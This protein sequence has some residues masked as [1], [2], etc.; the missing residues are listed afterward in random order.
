MLALA[1]CSPRHVLAWYSRATR[2]SPR[3]PPPADIVFNS[4]GCYLCDMTDRGPY[5]GPAS[6]GLKA[7]PGVTSWVMP[8]PLPRRAA[9]YFAANLTV[10]AA[11]KSEVVYGLGQGGWTPE[12][13]CPAAGAAGAAIVPLERNG[14]TVKLQQRKFHVSIPFLSSTAGY[15]F[16]FNMPGYGGV[17]IGEHGVGG[18]AWSQEAALYL[19]FW[20]TTL[21][22]DVV[23]PAPGPIYHQYADATGHAPPLREDAMSFWQSRNRYKSNDIALSIADRYQQ[24]KLD[25]GVL[26][27]DYKNQLRD[28]D[29]APN[30]A[31]YPS[32][33]AL[34]SGVRKK[35]NATLMYSFWPEVWA[36]SP[37]YPVLR[38]AGCLINPDLSGLAFDATIPTCRELVWSKM[39]KPRYYDQGVDAF[40][41]DETDGEGTGGGGDGDYGYN[42][43]YG[44]AVAYSNLWVNE[45][46]SMYSDPVA[47]QPGQVAPPLVLTRGVW[48]GGQRYGV[49]LWSSDIHSSFEQLASQVPQGVHASMSGIPWWTTDVGGYGCDKVRSPTDPYMQQLIVRWYQFGAFSPVFRTHGCRAGP[50][51][52]NTKECAPAQG[53][54]GYNEIWSYGSAAQVMLEKMV[55]LRSEVIKPYIQELDRNVTSRGVPTMRPLS[56]EFPED[57]KCRG[58]NDQYMLGPKYL[59]APV[60]VENATTR[61]LYFPAGADWLDFLGK[62]PERVIRGGQRLTVEAPLDTIPVYSR[63]AETPTT[64]GG[65]APPPPAPPALPSCHGQNRAFCSQSDPSTWCCN[66]KV[67][68]CVC[69]AEGTQHDI[70]FF[71]SA[72]ADDGIDCDTC[73]SAPQCKPPSTPP[74]TRSPPTSRPH[75]TPPPTHQHPACSKC[76]PGTPWAP[77]SPPTIPPRLCVAPHLRKGCDTAGTGGRAGCEQAGCCWEQTGRFWC[78]QIGPTPPAPPP[79]PTVWIP[80]PDPAETNGWCTDCADPKWIDVC[81]DAGCGTR[82]PTVAPP[83][84]PRPHRNCEGCQAGKQWVN[85]LCLDCNAIQNYRACAAAGC[86]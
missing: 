26:V 60:T 31:C 43:S 73:P 38:D 24:L 37:E 47:A 9:G 32:V 17:S 58:I 34:S 84:T 13:G 16:L 75:P 81:A 65:S 7:R 78:S 77:S 86:G 48:A 1:R 67:V 40:W 8:T 23:A 52:P 45:W 30:P 3:P 83:P 41:L 62:D 64:L 46:I 69:V 6:W 59:V 33:K 70:E 63:R 25:V 19:D 85:G 39:L 53:S 54:C 35:L 5:S 18:A 71:C 36:S 27:I 76:V 15:G 29:F 55:R 80:N 14:Q 11:D 56:Y 66:L 2:V 4:G 20:V 68:G 21:P 22:A 50:S 28:G 79:G 42:T 49:V 74:T 51:E 61:T 57:R 44:P 10:T 82:S 72:T 12:G